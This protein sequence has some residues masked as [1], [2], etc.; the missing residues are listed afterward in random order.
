MKSGQISIPSRYLVLL[1]QSKVIGVSARIVDEDERARLKG[2]VSVVLL[3][4]GAGLCFSLVAVAARS[5]LA[6][7]GFAAIASWN[8]LAGIERVTGGRWLGRRG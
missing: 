2:I 5:L 4:F 8:D 7:A 6:D 1:P 3:A